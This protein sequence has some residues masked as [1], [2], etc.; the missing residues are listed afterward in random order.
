MPLKVFFARLAPRSTNDSHDTNLR[1][2][3]HSYMGSSNARRLFRRS[4]YCH[5]E[6]ID[7][8]I[9]RQHALNT[10][11]RLDVALR[12]GA[13][14]SALG[15]PYEATC[16]SKADR[17]KIQ[18]ELN[19]EKAALLGSIN[20]TR[21]GEGV[22]TVNE[23]DQL[24]NELQ[25]YADNV[26]EEIPALKSSLNQLVPTTPT[27]VTPSTSHNGTATIRLISPPSLGGLACGELWYGGKYKR[28]T[29]S[30]PPVKSVH[31]EECPCHQKAVFDIVIH[32]SW[33]TVG[34]ARSK[35]RHWVVELVSDNIP[36][37]DG[38]NEIVTAAQPDTMKALPD[39]PEDVVAEAIAEENEPEEKRTTVHSCVMKALPEIP[40]EEEAWGGET[41]WEAVTAAWEG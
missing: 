20:L 29:N 23:D 14:T 36:G 31:P 19:R 28:H 26:M 17:D 3:Q 30:A 4:L 25:F 34:L 35:G 6:S 24:S 8:A 5:R 32:E 13:F 16:S 40:E 18:R 41:L 38:T 12:P 2:S 33:K 7:E 37:D 21:R 11:S 1:S 9:F 22:S 15:T 10:A 39:I 27:I